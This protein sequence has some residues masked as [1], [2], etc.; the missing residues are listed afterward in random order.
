MGMDP[1]TE[2]EG[3]LGGAGAGRWPTAHPWYD[4]RSVNLPN[5]ITTLRILLVPVF[6]WLFLSERAFAAMVVFAAAALSDGLDGLLARILDQRT[7]LGAILDPIADKF[8][9][10]TALILLVVGGTVPL[11][12]LVAALARDFVVTGVALTARA[13]ARWLDAA[14]TRISKYATFTLMLT[15]F[16]SL[17]L[18]AGIQTEP[19]A[20]FLQVV[21]VLAAQCLIVASFQYLF[22]WRA[23]LVAE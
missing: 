17:A 23:L 12:L 7:R 5:A 21:A 18:R 14:P 22:R 10:V 11:W 1:S 2:V 8:L 13:R 4:R 6:A 16:L 19:A 15:I 20:P 3:R 9:A